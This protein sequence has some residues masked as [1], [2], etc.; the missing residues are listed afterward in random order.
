MRQLLQG[1]NFI[2]RGQKGHYPNTLAQS[3]NNV[4][5]PSATLGQHYSNQNPL[6]SY[7]RLD[8]KYNREY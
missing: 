6:I 7:Y 3:L 2:L 1:D 8:H 5:L 4:G